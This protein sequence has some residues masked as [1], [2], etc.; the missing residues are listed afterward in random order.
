MLRRHPVQG[1]AKLHYSVD[2]I[3]RHWLAAWLLKVP[4][5]H[6]H[7]CP[8][9]HIYAIATA[10]LEATSCCLCMAHMNC[11]Q[12]I[13]TVITFLWSICAVSSNV[14]ILW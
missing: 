2:K 11:P 14:A 8:C 4:Q 9:V 3:A 5:A 6:V 13:F 10:S 12:E 7:I 1:C